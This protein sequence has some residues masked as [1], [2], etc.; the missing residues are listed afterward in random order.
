MRAA[1][2]ILLP[3]RRA[4]SDGPYRGGLGVDPGVVTTFLGRRTSRGITIFT[5]HRVEPLAA[6]GEAAARLLA[7]HASARGDARSS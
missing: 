7:I 1:N 4:R 5:E 6:S 3:K 2:R